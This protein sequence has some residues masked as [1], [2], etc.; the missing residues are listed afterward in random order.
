MTATVTSRV[1]SILRV[2]SRGHPHRQLTEISRISGLP[3]STVHRL[4]AELV[5]CGALERSPEDRTYNIGPLIWELGSLSS[6][7]VDLREVAL[8]FLSDVHAATGQ[9]VVLAV[10]DDMD[11]IYIEHI[12]GPRSVRMLNHVATRYPLHASGVGLVLLA[13]GPWELR[14]A[15]LNS[16]LRAFTRHTITDSEEL[17]RALDRVKR[18]GYAVSLRQIEELSMSVAAPIRDASGEV[19]A[20]ISI[21]A[22]IELEWNP[23][24]P[25]LVAAALGIS[26]ALGAR[27]ENDG[28]RRLHM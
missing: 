12:S 8:P 13:H 9:N 11:A 1:F 10:R 20:A 18:D 4:L 15:V 27:V 28:I 7:S 23:F 2:F 6:R 25:T 16:Q 22:P 19:T 3:L 17:R 5:D 14:Q 21:V 26:R 24:T